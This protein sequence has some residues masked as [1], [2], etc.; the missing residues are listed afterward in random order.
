MDHFYQ[1]FVIGWHDDTFMNHFYQIFVIGWPQLLSVANCD[2]LT[3]IESN[4]HK[5][6]TRSRSN[7]GQQLQ[8]HE[9]NH[10]MNNSEKL[11]RIAYWLR[12]VRMP[13][14][15]EQDVMSAM[16]AVACRRRPHTLLLLDLPEIPLEGIQPDWALC[17]AVEAIS[18]QNG[19]GFLVIEYYFS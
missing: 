17:A 4:H 6:Q 15:F 19:V 5:H 18:L 16:R 2:M 3:Y 12:K 7:S 11:C 14:I 1:T 13:L 9:R 10:E 8:R